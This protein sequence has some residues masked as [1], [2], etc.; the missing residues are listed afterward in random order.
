[1]ILQKIKCL[2]PTYKKKKNVSFLTWD[3]LPNREVD[4]DLRRC[5]VKL[6]APVTFSVRW[7][8]DSNVDEFDNQ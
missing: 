8:S 3:I 1:M 7:R 2:F 5:G 4:V 6:A